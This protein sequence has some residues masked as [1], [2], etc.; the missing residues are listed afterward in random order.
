MLYLL[1]IPCLRNQL[2]G[3]IAFR[4]IKYSLAIKNSPPRGLQPYHG[5]EVFAPQWPGELCWRER[6]LLVGP[7]MLDRPKGRGQTKCSPW[8]SRLGFT[9]LCFI[10][11]KPSFDE[12]SFTFLYLSPLIRRCDSVNNRIFFKPFM[13]HTVHRIA[14]FFLVLLLS[15]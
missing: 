3:I 7:P 1:I 6:K 4:A 12:C 15:N 2:L 14:P 5:E 8:S 9:Y 11:G 10:S 13:K